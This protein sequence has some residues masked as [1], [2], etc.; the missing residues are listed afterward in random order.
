[1]KSWVLSIA[2]LLVISSWAPITEGQ[3]PYFNWELGKGASSGGE[4]KLLSIDIPQTWDS[5]TNIEYWATIKFE[6]ARKPEIQR[7]CFKFS[8]GSQSCVDVQA[9]DVR[10]PSHSDFRV[11]VRVPAGTK[12]IDCYAEYIRDGK[13]KRTNTITYHIIILKKPDE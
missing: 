5:S 9:K 2:V 11:S 8:G 3:E 13:A 4:L 12:R 7:A 6:A 10:Y 1:M